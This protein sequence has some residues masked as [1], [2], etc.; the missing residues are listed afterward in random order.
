MAPTSDFR[1]LEGFL[2]S[3]HDNRC[4][5]NQKKKTPKNNHTRTRLLFE[6]QTPSFVGLFCS[7]SML[8]S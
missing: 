8:H 6:Q 5:K 7:S 4:V 3:L 2:P 1:Y